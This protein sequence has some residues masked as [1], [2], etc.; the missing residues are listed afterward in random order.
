MSDRIGERFSGNKAKGVGSLLPYFT[1]GFPDMETAADLIRTADSAGATV[2]EIG[3]PYSDSI[4]DGPVIQ[5]SFQYALDHGHRTEKTIEM[6]AALRPQVSA[7]LVSMISYTLVDRFGLDGYLTAAAQAGLDGVIFPDLPIEESA[8]IAGAVR[9]AGLHYVGLISP[10]TAPL[11]AEA[12]AR[13]SAGFVYQVAD[14][15]TTGERA[16]VHQGLP[17]RVA[18]LRRCTDLPICVGFGVASSAQVR[19]VCRWA[20]GAIVGSAIVRRIADGLRSGAESGR[21]VKQVHSFLAELM[22]G[23][24]NA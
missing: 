18:A 7:G 17:D 12:I 16:H 2:I 21:I 23:L 9:S 6:I 3:E 11:R 14:I 10:T 22:T 15:G 24:S 19:E 1:A 13:M 8:P 20:D 4:A 5:D